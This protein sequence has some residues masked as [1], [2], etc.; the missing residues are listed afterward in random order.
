MSRRRWSSAFGVDATIALLT[1]LIMTGVALLG[2]LALDWPRPVPATAPPTEFSSARALEH[3]RAIAQQP[4]LMGSPAN[5][6]VRDYLVQNSIP[7]N[8][9]TAVG[10]GKTRPVASND[11]AAGRQQNR[12]VELVV[13]G[14]EIGNTTSMNTPV[15][16]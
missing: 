7:V 3:I 11:N 5:A 14:E 6:A 12:R 13:S 16:P 2:A 15:R 4:H 1:F 9:V 8:N 10:F